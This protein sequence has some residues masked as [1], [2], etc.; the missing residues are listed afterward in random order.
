MY[1]VRCIEFLKPQ[2]EVLWPSVCN[3]GPTR[4]ARAIASSRARSPSVPPDQGFRLDEASLLQNGQTTLARNSQ[5][6]GRLG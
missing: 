2:A 5:D 3:A 1:A 4:P 6:H